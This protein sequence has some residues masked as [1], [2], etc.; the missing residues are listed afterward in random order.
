MGYAKL[1]LDKSQALV[2]AVRKD[3]IAISNNFLTFFTCIS[4]FL[5]VY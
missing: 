2:Y 3:G 1:I 4:Q 5:V